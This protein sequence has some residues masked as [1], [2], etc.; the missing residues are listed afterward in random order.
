M[1][2]EAKYKPSWIGTLVLS[3]VLAGGLAGATFARQFDSAYLSV[4]N[5]NDE[6]RVAGSRPI[7]EKPAPPGYMFG[8]RSDRINNHPNDDGWGETGWSG[9]G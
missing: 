6:N 4:K 5:N 3:L 9:G 7:N 2:T 1:N 8:G